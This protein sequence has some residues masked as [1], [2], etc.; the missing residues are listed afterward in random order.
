MKNFKFLF[1]VI[2]PILFSCTAT[3]ENHDDELSFDEV[4]K[5]FNMKKPFTDITKNAIINR[6][7][8]VKNYYDIG[9]ERK[10]ILENK[11]KS[12]NRFMEN[13][14]SS[15]PL[16]NVRLTNPA[17]DINTRINVYYDEHILDV[18]IENGIDLPY[19]CRCGADPVSAA[20]Q[21][22]GTPA[23][24]SEQSFLND[25]QI[26]AGFVLLDVAVPTSDCTF[27]THQE[28]NIWDY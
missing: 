10:K 24:Q 7:G 27:L 4:E 16:Y 15:R 5:R 1:L 11:S 18:A 19:S 14:R 22:S 17:F 3:V 28:E 26:E 21:M 20:K 25:Y 12:N 23:D 9:I 8:S 13:V 2:V 6:Y